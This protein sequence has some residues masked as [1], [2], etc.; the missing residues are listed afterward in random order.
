MTGEQKYLFDLKGYVLL[1]GAIPPDAIAR[2]H[3]DMTAHGVQNPENDPG[4]SRFRGFLEWGPDW[5]NLID[6]P[7]VLPVLHTI[8]GDKFRL[9]HAYGM[10]ARSDGEAGNFGMHHEAGMFGHG[11]YYTTHGDTMHNGLIVVSYALTDTPAGAG[12]FCCISGSHKS[13]YPTP[14]RLYSASNNPLIEQVPVKAGDVIVFTEALTHGTMRWTETD[15][16]RRA[17]LLKYCPA[18]M[19]WSNGRMDSS[20][21]EFTERQRRILDGPYVWQGE[22]VESSS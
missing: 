14:K 1:H 10:A 13:I 19:Q 3:E 17:V 5:R 16:E 12:G 15:F 6:H 22:T 7:D 20:V 8:L 4:K 21:E 18:Y 11:C 9:D 2:M